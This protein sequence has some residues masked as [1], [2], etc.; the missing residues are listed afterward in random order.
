MIYLRRLLQLKYPKQSSALNLSRAQELLVG[1]SYM[2]IDYR[3]ELEKWR[4]KDFYDKNMLNIQLPVVSTTTEKDLELRKVQAR[5]LKEINQ[6]KRE[7]KLKVEQEEL[8]KYLNISNLESYN[9]IAFKLKLKQEGLRSESEL[10]SVITELKQKIMNREA[11]SLKYLQEV[12]GGIDGFQV[13]EGTMPIEEAEKLL[14]SLESEKLILIDK[15]RSRVS[16]KQALN[17]RKSYASKERMRILTQLAK[18]GNS[19]VKLSNEDTFGM[20][21]DDWDVY[22]YINKDGS[23]SEDEQDQERLNELEQSLS[24][25]QI[26][27]NKLMIGQ[28]QKYQ[29]LPFDTEQIRVPELLYQPNLIGTEQEGLTGMIEYVLKNYEPDIQEKLIQNI[30]LTGGPSKFRGFKERLE[31]ETRAILPFLSKFNIHEASDKLCDAWHGAAEMVRETADL[32]DISMDAKDY[33]E[34]GLGYFKEHKCSNIF[35]SFSEP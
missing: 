5:R 2:A 9:S 17:K 21:D 24:Q 34:Q 12:P 7:E 25:Y 28:G 35:V 31:V 16:R 11:K 33:E 23:D 22:K 30:F 8:A 4:N 18:S 26:L 32:A 14:S 27:L 29:Y 3:S 1:H 19:S 15:R 6:K 10:T 20:N 13:V